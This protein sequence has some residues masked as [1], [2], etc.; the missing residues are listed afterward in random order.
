MCKKAVHAEVPCGSGHTGS[1]TDPKGALPNP[2]TD[3]L[4]PV[5]PKGRWGTARSEFPCG[6]PPLGLV[7]VAYLSFSK[8]TAFIALPATCT[9]QRP[10]RACLI[11][12]VAN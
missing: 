5:L 4:K 2:I 3:T 6:T 10:L 12:S 7:H 9:V 8:L 11:T 1:Y